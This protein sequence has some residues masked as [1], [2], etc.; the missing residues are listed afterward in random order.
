MPGFRDHLETCVARAGSPS[1]SRLLLGLFLLACAGLLLV[2]RPWSV[3]PGTT[4]PCGFESG[5]VARN[6]VAGYGYASPFARLPGDTFETVP[7]AS[8]GRPP[9]E[10]DTG[11]PPPTAWVTPPNTLL[12]WLVFAL[13]G[14]YTPAALAA[15]LVVQA[16]LT[17]ISI[18][19]AR[20]LLHAAAGAVP[21]GLGV[22]CFLAYPGTWYYAVADTHGTVLFALFAFL[23]LLSLHR[24]EETGRDGAL[25]LHG[26]ASALAVLCEPASLLFFVGWESR[27]A[28]RW[29]RRPPANP[30]HAPG[31][32]RPRRGLTATRFALVI[33]LCAAALWAPWL[34]RNRL[35]LGGWVLFK[36]NMPMELYF[37]NNAGSRANPY[38]AHAER[39]PAASESER[40]QLLG[41]GEIAYGRLC[42]SRFA[43]FVTQRPADFLA[44]TAQRILWFW[45]LHPF[46][47]NPLRPALTVLFWA[48]LTFWMIGRL[49]S[50][51]RGGTIDRACLWFLVL[52][53]T[54]FY[55]SHFFLYRYRHPLE[56]LLLLAAALVTAT[57]GP[58]TSTPGTAEKRCLHPAG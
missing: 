51:A 49:R 29:R 20:R 48:V 35:A 32:A 27:C 1:G 18:E 56:A 45:S 9:V 21:A 26:L 30:G 33:V 31:S 14:T 38:A 44:L 16:I 34:V 4:W 25:W 19:V 55:L 11:P 54:G 2:T 58:T 50:P 43:D 7:S 40:R 3:L 36:S 6:L 41:M 5:R 52:Y 22:L 57:R 53:P 13:F 17:A 24:L 15:Y 23:S 10:G 42:A 47:P 39:F 12:W 37:G 46:K 28:L 8:P